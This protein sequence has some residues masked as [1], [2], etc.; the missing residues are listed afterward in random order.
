MVKGIRIKLD[1][2][3]KLHKDRMHCMH[4]LWTPS[5]S[6]KKRI[7]NSNEMAKFKLTGR[8]ENGGQFPCVL[9]K[10]LICYGL[11]K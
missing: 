3:F 1:L 11:N 9:E 4:K 7:A 5:S 8:V 2:S 6:T 10:S